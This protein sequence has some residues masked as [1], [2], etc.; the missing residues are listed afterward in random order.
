MVVMSRLRQIGKRSA[1]LARECGWSLPVL[2]LVVAGWFIPLRYLV[3][4][5]TVGRRAGRQL[6]SVIEEAAARHGVSPFLIRAMIEQESRADSCQ[7]GA[8]G[9]IGLMQLTPLAVKDWERATGRRCPC[10]GALFNIYLNVEIGTWYVGRALNRW[11]A[12]RDSIV[13]ALAEY[14]AGPSRARE[15][16]PDD[17]RENALARVRFPGTKDY[18]VKIIRF[19]E[20]FEQD[21]YRR[22]QGH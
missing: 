13:L 12:Y 17:P 19:R 10:R 4:Q 21:A 18:I 22:E 5:F 16:A 9:E 15:W 1:H 8:V 7:V 14:N 2:V 20:K 3:E 11:R 6:D